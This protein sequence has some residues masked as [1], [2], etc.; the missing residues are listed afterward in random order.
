MDFRFS[1]F[2]PIPKS[3]YI[4]SEII[5]DNFLFTFRKT[6]RYVCT[7][8]YRIIFKCDTSVCNIVDNDYP[9][10]GNFK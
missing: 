2:I 8:L 5:F 9:E 6:R 4:I 1:L 10:G 3:Y 7:K